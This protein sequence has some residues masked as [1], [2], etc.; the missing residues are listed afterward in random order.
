[1]KGEPVP[2]AEQGLGLTY[3]MRPRLPSEAYFHL[4]SVILFLLKEQQATIE[5]STGQ[6][7]LPLNR[8][9]VVAKGFLVGILL[10]ES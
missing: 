3:G 6:M 2:L 4:F 10:P 1:M 9:V 8:R 5:I 7:R